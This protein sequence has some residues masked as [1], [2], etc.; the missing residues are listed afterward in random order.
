MKKE[1]IVLWIL[2]LMMVLL[3]ADQMVM[4]PNIGRIEK[5]FSIGDREIGY[6][7]GSFTIIGALL[8]LVWGFLA[9]KYKR[10][11]LLLFSVLVG[12]IPCF[13]SAFA[14]SYPQLFLL[15]ALTGIGIGAVFPVVFSYASDIFNENERA[16]VNAILSTA[17]SIGAILGMIIAGFTGESLGWRIPFMIVSLPNLI[18]AFLFYLIAKEPERGG[19]EVAVGDLVREGR[20]YN[21]QV[22]LSDYLDLFKIKTNL[23]LF[24]QGILGTIPWG[25]IPYFLVEFL[26]R[27]KGLD[28]GKATIV[29]IFFGLGNVLGIFFGGIVGGILYNKRKAYMPLFSA[30]MT[31]IGALLALAVLNLPPIENSVGF[32]L[33]SLLGMIA[34]ATASMTG[35]NMKTMLMNVNVPENRGRIF[36]IFNITDSLGTGLGKVFAGSISVTLGSLSAAMNISALFWLPCAFALLFS[37]YTLSKDVENLHRKMKQTAKLM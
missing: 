23:V 22:R 33:I 18:F 21:A 32:L 31:A 15:R 8:S 27:Y 30:I 29:F 20:K 24:I 2:L 7:A 9:D 25:A 6:I 1:S 28:Q 17:I 16:K 26:Q 5:E 19:A 14:T 10:K 4:A 3:N 35:P 37:A 36:S 12:E 13:F 34:A 11:K